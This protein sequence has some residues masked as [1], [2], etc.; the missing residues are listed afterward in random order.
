MATKVF[1]A[2]ILLFVAMVTTFSTCKKGSLGCANTVFNF[3]I[4]A[5]A[6]PDKDSILVG[7]TIWLEIDAPTKLTD[8]NS[9]TIVDYSGADNLRNALSF[10]IFTGGSV[11]DPG[12]AYAA[13]DFNFSLKT[14]SAIANPYTER[15]REYLFIENNSSF[16]FKLAI[17]PKKKGIFALAISNAANVYRG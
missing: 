12:T 5:K 4:G 10:D 3:K 7:D 13:N 15:I 16:K 14:G 6:Y 17:I 1:T 2:A 11:S 8:I 9:N